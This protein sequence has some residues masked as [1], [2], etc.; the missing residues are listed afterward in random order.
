M[1]AANCDGATWIVVAWL[2]K[3]Q[4]FHDLLTRILDWR[5]QHTGDTPMRLCIVGEA[6]DIWAEY[7]NRV[8]KELREGGR[9]HPIREWGSKQAGRVARIA[10]GLHVAN[11]I[12]CG[13]ACPAADTG[14]YRPGAGRGAAVIG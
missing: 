10:G 13:Q 1:L 9:L 8:E 14:S 5:R 3:S 2:H 7:A 4:E 6:L 11:T 12:G